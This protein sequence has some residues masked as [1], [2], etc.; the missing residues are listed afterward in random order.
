MGTLAP[1][2]PAPEFRTVSHDGRPI[3]LSDFRGKQTVVV[4]FYPRDHTSICTQQACTFR[5]AYEEFV[6]NGAV[7]IGVSADSAERHQSF[8]AA[9]HL[10]FLLVSDA[11]GSLRKAFRVPKSLG[12]L[13]GRV[14]YIIDRAGIVR[15]VFNSQLQGKKHVDEALRIV[16]E[17]RDEAPGP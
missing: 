17:L 13:P 3:A 2:D 9:Q 11:D 10:P 6:D 4:Y 16:R 1:G 7:V 5:D 8:A 14:T 12:F 15:H